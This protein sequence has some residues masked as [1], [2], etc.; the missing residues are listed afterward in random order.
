MKHLAAY[1]LLGL[2]GNTSP[3][4]ADVK[5][6]LESV[7]IE[8]DDE[9]LNTL[10]SELKGKDI[11]EGITLQQQH[12]IP[13]VN[14]HQPPNIP[15]LISY[16]HKFTRSQQSEKTMPVCGA[17]T[18][19][20]NSRYRIPT[21]CHPRRVCTPTACTSSPAPRHGAAAPHQVPRPDGSATRLP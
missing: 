12:A 10:I 13:T 15:K 8:A 2:G 9:R 18:A 17:N 14:N 5:A 19:A 20:P 1:L 11:N 16:V 6:V 21:S 7:G 4:A 3:S